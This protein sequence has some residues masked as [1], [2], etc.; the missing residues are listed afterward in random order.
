M[1]PIFLK[2]SR[3][4]WPKT[5]LTPFIRPAPWPISHYVIRLRQRINVGS[6]KFK[7]YIFISARAD[8]A[9][10]CW[11]EISVKFEK[12]LPLSLALNDIEDVR[13]QGRHT[14]R[15]DIGHRRR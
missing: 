3:R 8:T 4:L 10:T 13:S 11:V 9:T 2:H 7:F 6:I 15:L 1:A 12:E 14:R 5:K